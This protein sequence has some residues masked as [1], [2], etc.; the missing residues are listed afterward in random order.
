MIGPYNTAWEIMAQKWLVMFM[1]HVWEKELNK[2][3][4]TK[5][6][7]KNRQKFGLHRY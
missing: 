6:K 3:V 2:A 7:K 4:I 5:K 1:V